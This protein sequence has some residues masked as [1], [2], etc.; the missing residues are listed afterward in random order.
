M[1]KK[2]KKRLEYRKGPREDL[3]EMEPNLKEGSLKVVTLVRFGTLSFQMRHQKKKGT[4][5]GNEGGKKI[6]RMGK[7]G[8]NH[9]YSGPMTHRIF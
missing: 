2:E 4:Q 6:K 5:Y 9:W 7:L 1:T 3:M 8:N